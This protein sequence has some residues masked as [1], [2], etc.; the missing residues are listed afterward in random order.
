[1]GVTMSPDIPTGPDDR[2]DEAIVSFRVVGEE[3]R[4]AELSAR[5]GITP[6]KAATM[7]DPHPRRPERR[8]PRGFWVVDSPLPPSAPLEDHLTVLLDRLEPHRDALDASRIAW[9]AYVGFLCTLS[10]DLHSS[11]NLS[12]NLSLPPDLLRRVTALGA[13]LDIS[14]Y[15][16]GV[17]RTA[18]DSYGG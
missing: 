18:S 6:D 2:R 15:C 17:G 13:H 4:P 3:V 16:D 10:S 14:F 1:M 5:L 11:D 12:C 8:Y 7:G 9:A